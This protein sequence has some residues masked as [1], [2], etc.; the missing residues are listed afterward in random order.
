MYDRKKSK[1]GF[2]T[3]Q[4]DR[5]LEPLKLGKDKIFKLL[6][7]DLARWVSNLEKVPSETSTSHDM[8]TILDNQSFCD[9]S[10]FDLDESYGLDKAVSPVK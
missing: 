6:N 2:L 5:Y 10:D 8:K 7:D 4:L 1:M 3:Y 9:L